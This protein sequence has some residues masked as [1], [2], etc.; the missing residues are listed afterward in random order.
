[1]LS[2]ARRYEHHLNLVMVDLDNFKQFNDRFGHAVGDAVLVEVADVL[3]RPKRSTDSVFRWGGDEFVVVLP[4]VRPAAAHGAMERIAGRLSQTEVQRVRLGASVGR[5]RYPDDGR[6]DLERA[7]G[8][9]APPARSARNTANQAA[10]PRA[11]RPAARLGPRRRRR[12]RAPAPPPLAPPPA[13]P[14][15]RPPPAAARS[16]PACSRGA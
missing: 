14:W 6:G 7:S 16:A 3:R 5:A 13:R 4:E 9:G 11:R 10:V 15:A 2:C 8:L 1:E 12:A